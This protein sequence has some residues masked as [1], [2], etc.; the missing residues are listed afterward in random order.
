MIVG[1]GQWD[2]VNRLA[3]I[4]LFVLQTCPKG[5]TD[6]DD[7]LDT[8]KLH[9][10]GTRQGVWDYQMGMFAQPFRRSSG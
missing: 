2:N 7:Q 9:V 1:G 5:P 3:P 6:S 10:F 8:D 4:Q